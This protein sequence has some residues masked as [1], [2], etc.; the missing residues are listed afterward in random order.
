VVTHLR[1]EFTF[2]LLNEEF[3]VM[4]ATTV[5][6][7]CY[8]FCHPHGGTAFKKVGAAKLGIP[9]WSDRFWL[10]IKFKEKSYGG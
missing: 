3:R 4:L 6:L 5:L 10:N 7:I 1:S 8:S 9:A 2:F